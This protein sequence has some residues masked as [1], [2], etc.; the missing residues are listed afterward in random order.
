MPIW[1]PI[2]HQ[3]EDDQNMGYV[4]VENVVEYL[5]SIQHK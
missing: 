2:C 3:I 1:G 5:K 4:R